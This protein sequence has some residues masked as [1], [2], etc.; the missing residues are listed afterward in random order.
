MR[1][2]DLVNLNPL[3]YNVASVEGLYMRRPLIRYLITS[4]YTVEIITMSLG[5][6]LSVPKITMDEL[7][8]VIDAPNEFLIAA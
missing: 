3:F 2:S 8:T 4:L 6:G 1:S 5:F 7:C